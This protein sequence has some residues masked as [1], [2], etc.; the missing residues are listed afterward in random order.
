MIKLYSGTPGS[1]KSLHVAKDIYKRLNRNKVHPNVI[2]N[3]IIND[4]MIKGKKAKFI[5]KDNSELTVDFLVSYA[6]KNHKVGKENQTLVVVDECQVIWNAREWQNNNDRMSWIKFFSQHRH[7]GFNFI[8]ITQNDRMIDK[9]I[10]A[11]IEYQ[12]VHRKVNNFKIGA[13]MPFPTFVSIERWY[14]I[15]EKLNSEFFTYTKKWGKFYDSYANFNFGNSDSVSSP[16]EEGLGVPSPLAST[17]II[18]K[19]KFLDKIKSK[20]HFKS[21]KK[22]SI[23]N[24]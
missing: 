17:E 5:Y 6:Y 21:N 19:D 22:I 10:R 13:L 14:G 18:K 12:C 9:Q 23:T 2:A 3:F 1:G 20:F 7:L 4:K 8:L 24:E 15:N 16:G 11:L